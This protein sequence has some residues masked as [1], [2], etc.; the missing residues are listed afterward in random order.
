MCYDPYP[1][2]SRPEPLPRGMSLPQ[3]LKF[4]KL[5]FEMQPRLG[6]ASGQGR[7]IYLVDSKRSRIVLLWIYTHE[8]F[9]KRPDDQGLRNEIQAGLS[10]LEDATDSANEEQN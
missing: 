4:S 8:E 7:L 10:L 3:E 6:G 9:P 2:Q 1:P 5:R